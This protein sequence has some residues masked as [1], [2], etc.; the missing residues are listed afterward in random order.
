MSFSIGSSSSGIGPRSALSQFG[1]ANQE[2]KKVNSKVFIRLLGYLKPYWLH[3][4]IAF[5]LTLVE[6][7]LTLL[8]PYLIKVALDQHIALNDVDGL[9]VISLQIG[10]SFLAVFIVSSLQR[11]L[12]SWVSQRLLAKLRQDLFNHLQ[13]LHLGYHDRR[14]FGVTVS[15]V[16]N[17]VAEINEL[18][19]Q[20]LITLLGDLI[21]LIG[22]IVIM[23][24]MNIKLALITFTVIPLMILATWLFSK[25]ASVAFR[26]TRS[27]VAAVVGDLA[28]DISGMR[29]IQ[30]FAQEKA[31][32]ERFDKVNQENKNAYINA[33]TL[34]FIFLPT[35][36]FLS[37]LATAIVLWFGGRFVLQEQLTVGIVVAFLSYVTRFFQPIQE[38]SRM[39]TT[40]QSAVAGGEQVLNL[41]DTAPEIKDNE[42]AKTLDV[43]KGSIKFRDV[44]F[45][46]NPTSPLVLNSLNLNIKANTTVAI[47]GPTGAGKT[48]IANLLARFYDVTSGYIEIDGIDIRDVTQESLRRQVRVISQEPFLFS[49]SIADNIRYGMPSATDQEIELAARQ[50]NA[51][52]FIETLPEGYQTKILEGGV[53]V[54]H[55][56]RQLISIA[57]AILSN[58]KILILDE[59]TANI[60]I[61]TE[62]LIQKALSN[63]L[64]DKTAII[65]AHRLST[66]RNADWV[67]VLDEGEVAEQGT[68]EMLIDLRGQYFNLYNRQFID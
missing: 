50:A 1:N 18:I 11:Y 31:S 45:R 12:V 53:N 51:H 48:T 30:A 67:Y 2:P 68:H 60:D 42:N 20:G 21:V 29:A 3:M 41:L 14:F 37:M 35:I 10:L 13:F 9:L 19:S 23:L 56:Q 46:Y 5:L 38:L 33:M 54:S 36:E 62:L 55:G 24:L 39:F 25:Q 52:D 4:G 58:P 28:E 44:S 66:V 32:Q 15:R 49:C 16:I 47:V 63:L 57:R 17:D 65:I 8:T 59:A 6:S 22:I 27:K 7:G 64:K 34:S 43:K 40:F 26:N 61:V